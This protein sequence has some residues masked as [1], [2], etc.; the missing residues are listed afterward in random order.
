MTI[1]MRKP[2]PMYLAAVAEVRVAELTADP[3]TSNPTWPKSRTCW[4]SLT[5]A[6]ERRTALLAALHQHLPPRAG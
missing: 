4:I 1:T 6:A 2:I 5:E 3:T